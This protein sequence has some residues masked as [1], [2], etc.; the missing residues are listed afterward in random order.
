MR[1]IIL[2]FFLAAFTLAVVAPMGPAFAR[3]GAD[4]PVGHD[5]GDD[6]GGR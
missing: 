6:H 3:D 5:A 2:T 1:R 4:D